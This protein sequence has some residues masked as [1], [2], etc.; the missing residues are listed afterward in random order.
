[1][2]QVK[3]GIIGAMGIEVNYLKGQLK[4]AKTTTI[5]QRDFYEGK[6]GST[7]V[8][9]VECG[10]GKVNAAMVAQTLCERYRVTHLI[11]TGV[12]GSLNNAINIGDI[13]VAKDA[14]HHDMDVTN[15]GYKPG[16]VPGIDSVAFPTDKHLQEL[17]LEAVKNV[18]PDI[19]GFSGR[20]ASGEFFVRSDEKKQRIIDTFHADCTE[21]EGAP[22]A[23]V[24]FLN[25]VP[26]VI[27]RA[28]SDKADGSSSMDYRTF[29][30]KA[31]EH[32]AQIV[33]YLVS[34]LTD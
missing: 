16:E 27:V 32:C 33:E 6:L 4:D 11:N 14:V 18:A 26:F 20:V 12:A 1:M 29:E 23:Q 19:E 5:S 17:A 24:A 21:M 3:V 2:A 28:I 34:H 13:V 25:K 7:D 8:V 9:V 22:I 15:L 31:A 30:N 10:V